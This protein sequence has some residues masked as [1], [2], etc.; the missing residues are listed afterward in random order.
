[1]NAIGRNSS[2]LSDSAGG[3]DVTARR[4][5]L[6]EID[7]LVR[8]SREDIDSYMSAGAWMNAS[9]GDLLRKAAR[10]HGSF[11]ALVA[12]GQRYSYR[13]YDEM[14]ERLASAMLRLG[15]R[16]GDRAMFQMGTVPETAIAL[17]ACFK[18]GVIPVCTLPQH[19]SVEIDTLCQITSPVAYFV[20]A[21]ASRF[22]LVSFA[23]ETAAKFPSLRNIIVARGDAPADCLSMAELVSCEPDGAADRVASLAPMGPEDV[24]VFQISGGT[25]GIPKV[26]PRFH[27]E[28]L[29]YCQGWNDLLELGKNDVHLWALP[30][31]HNASMIYHLVPAV[32]D[33]RKL[34]LLSRFDP[35]EF[36]GMIEREK[37][38]LT[39]SIGP[40]ASAI[41]DFGRIDEFDL[42]SIKAFTTLSRADA[43]ENHIKRPVVTVF[44]ISE[45][46][47]TGSHPNAPSD[48][49]H[50]TVGLPISTF[51]QIKLLEPNGLGEVGF[52]S[53][54]ELA[55]KGPSSIRGYFGADH[56]N[57]TSFTPDGFFRTGD[58][59]RAHEIDGAVYYSFEGRLKDNIDRGGE[60]FG[61][62]DIE[63]LIAR[64][65]TVMDVKVVAMPDP[66]YGEKP[67]AYI[68]A[69][70]G[71]VL[72]TE[73]ELSE[74]LLAEGLAKFKVPERIVPVDA[75]PTTQV[76]KVDKAAMRRMISEIL[77][78]ETSAQ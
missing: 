76:G 33:A 8:F 43:I 63:S 22:D 3:V 1:M 67:C 69:K 52:G 40:I 26:M 44:G 66:M 4:R 11:T 7:G 12:P 29:A 30:L 78:K 58:L 35:E 77:A 14:S 36:F 31:I 71:H 21:D 68:I 9:A 45:G 70:P 60:K 39:G 75:F 20:Q 50:K 55:F 16:P 24:M 6:Y 2:P 54:G 53:I 17:F 46:L 74:F 61:T 32:I 28:Y 5:P 37:V 47:L 15:L 49:R 10:E 48:A 56:L 19:R 72:P 65:A 27:G 38:T 13:E 41:L 42:S 25:T 62:E 57:A 18:C 34:C 23:R 51:D 64:H 59:L 73:S